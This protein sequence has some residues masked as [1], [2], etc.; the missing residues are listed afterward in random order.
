MIVD[1]ISVLKEEIYDKFFKE[2]PEPNYAAASALL[3]VPPYTLHTSALETVTEAALKKLAKLLRKFNR[4]GTAVVVLEQ[5]PP[6]G[7]QAASA[8]LSA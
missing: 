7:S 8:R 2:L 4:W 1:S 5:G 3:W 6:A